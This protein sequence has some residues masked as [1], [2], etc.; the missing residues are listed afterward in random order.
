MADQEAI[1]ERIR[2]M[3]YYDTSYGGEFIGKDLTINPIGRKIMK[4]I[5]N[6]PIDPKNK[7]E[8]FGVETGLGY[9]YNYIYIY[10]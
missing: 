6:K 5:D 8:Q 1:Q 4:T 2:R 9:R 3:G 10:I 7:D